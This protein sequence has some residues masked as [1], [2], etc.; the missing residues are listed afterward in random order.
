M[1]RTGRLVRRT[2]D[3]RAVLVLSAELIGKLHKAH[4]FP[5]IAFEIFSLEP[6]RTRGRRLEAAV[7]RVL[8]FAQHHAELGD[9]RREADVRAHWL[10]LDVHHPRDKTARVA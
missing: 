8:R 4:E 3:R 6:P 2:R 9:G 10:R 7:A 5:A 1:A